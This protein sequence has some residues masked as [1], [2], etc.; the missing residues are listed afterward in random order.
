MS[1]LLCC[2][3]KAGAL[4]SQPLAGEPRS[5]VSESVD[6]IERSGKSVEGAADLQYR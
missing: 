6:R 2:K 5:I 1:G 3:M 4:S